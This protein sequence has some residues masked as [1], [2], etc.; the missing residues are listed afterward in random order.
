MRGHVD[1]WHNVFLLYENIA[2]YASSDYENKLMLIVDCSHRISLCGERKRGE[3]SS[4]LETHIVNRA[5]RNGSI[6]LRSNPQKNKN[7]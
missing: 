3:V 1:L 4:I 6:S 2:D 5:G 7:H